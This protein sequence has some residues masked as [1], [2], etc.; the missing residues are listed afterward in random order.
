MPGRKPAIG[1]LETGAPA[2]AAASSVAAFRRR[3]AAL[4]AG[5][6]DRRPAC[7]LPAASPADGHRGVAVSLTPVALE[8]DSRAFRI[9]CALVDAGFRSIVVE[10]RASRNPFWGEAI[11]VRPLAPAGRERSG[12]RG[13]ALR[14]GRGGPAGELALYAAFRARDWWRHCRSPRRIVPPADLYY[15]HSFEFHR[16]VAGL[17][18]S[19]NARLIYDAHD[20]YR[21]IEPPE[22]RPAFDR[23]RVRPYFDALEDRLARAAHAIVT[24]SDGVARLMESAFG[25]V[26]LVIRNCHDERADRATAPDLRTALSLSPDDRLCVVVGNRKSGMA[27]DAAVAALRLLPENFHLAFVGRGYGAD[28]ER[29]RLH[30]IGG[31]VHF[32]SPVAPT[33]IV[34]FIRAADIGLL[35]YEPRSDN[36]R[37][38]LPNGFFQIIAAGLPLVRG[39]LPEVEAA[40]AGRPVGIRLEGLAPQPLAAAIGT[41]VAEPRPRRAASAELAAALSWSREVSR[42]YRLL[43]DVLPGV[44][45]HPRPEG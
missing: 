36:Y 7:P 14:G 28:R 39:S 44:S 6:A 45:R 8:A 21:G 22:N 10:G 33:E 9:A 20:F 18:A 27:L 12:L 13:G 43:D 4:P 35:L 38:A 42:L 19:G 37:F 32:A 11:E 30:P 16:A 24:V 26:P 31:R 40:I 15:L 3:I 23:N 29:L 17:A 34:P 1:P 2:R 41:C 25:R 5:A